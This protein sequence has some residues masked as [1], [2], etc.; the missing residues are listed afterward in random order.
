MNTL[1][2]NRMIEYRRENFAVRIRPAQNPLGPGEIAMEI[3]HNG[4]QWT[5]ICLLPEE[6]KKLAWALQANT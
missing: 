5:N 1:I 3:T 2:E 6:A 4:Y